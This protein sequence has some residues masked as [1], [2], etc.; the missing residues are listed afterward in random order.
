MFSRS[1]LSSFIYKKKTLD[2]ANGDQYYYV[3]NF[4]QTSDKECI[5][6]DK[7]NEKIYLKNVKLFNSMNE[8]L[9]NTPLNI[10]KQPPSPPKPTNYERLLLWRQRNV[11]KSV[12]AQTMAITYLMSKGIYVKF[13]NCRKDGVEPYEAIKIAEKIA[14]ENFER[15]P[16]KVIEYM[17]SLNLKPYKRKI[18]NKETKNTTNNT[19][20]TNTNNT[21]NT[22][23][24]RNNMNNVNQ[25]KSIMLSK[26]L[27]EPKK[28]VFTN[29]DNNI[30]SS[31]S[32]ID[33]C[34]F[35]LRRT[36]SVYIPHQDPPNPRNSIL[37]T[38]NG[39]SQ[40]PNY[41]NVTN[42]RLPEIIRKKNDNMT[43]Q[44]PEHHSY[45]DRLNYF[46][47]RTQSCGNFGNL[48]PDIDSYMENNQHP[49]VERRNTIPSLN[50]SANHSSNS[51]NNYKKREKPKRPPTPI[52]PSAPPP[53][54]Q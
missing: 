10:E 4:E 53:Y 24:S 2:R 6:F 27:C 18:S 9:S 36:Q 14:K 20:N 40:F 8:K 50:P 7:L 49:V 43:C 21:N 37:V 16:D 12:E 19:N 11:K 26:E 28:V 54:N 32:R 31:D 44:C 13:P 39:K 1:R 5:N 17:N 34:G 47:E 38:D 33:N 3:T 25:E 22:N 46:E 41:I 42:V 45:S 23:N 48:Y 51:G 52:L 35:D 15:I 29:L 30:S